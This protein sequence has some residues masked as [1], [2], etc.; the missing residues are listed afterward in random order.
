MYTCMSCFCYVYT[1]CVL[2]EGPNAL[3]WRALSESA[4]PCNTNDFGYGESSSGAHTVDARPTEDDPRDAILVQYPVTNCPGARG[5]LV[6]GQD[7]R[8]FEFGQKYT[9]RNPK[10][11]CGASRLGSVTQ[12]CIVYSFGSYDEISF[13]VGLH[14]AA[15]HCEVHVFDIDQVPDIESQ[16]RYNF[17]SH[18]FGIDVVRTSTSQ[19]LSDI[20]RDLGHSHV[21]VLK[22]DIEGTEERILPSLRRAGFSSYGID[23]LLVEFHSIRGLDRGMKLLSPYFQMVFGRK[24]DRCKSCTEVAFVRRT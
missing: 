16:R 6:A 24:E 15:P 2:R 4:T 5:C 11:V 14:E 21:T 20:M 1:R 10:F 22:L 13:E 23:Q 9:K 8:V 12:P 7:V 3:F 19:V 18:P 17:S